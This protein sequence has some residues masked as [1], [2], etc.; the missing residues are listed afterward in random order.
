MVNSFN[1]KLGN[2]DDVEKVL[3]A[4]IKA[5]DRDGSLVV[6]SDKESYPNQV[7]YRLYLEGQ[8]AMIQVSKKGDGSINLC[9]TSKNTNL[10]G[11][12]CKKVKQLVEEP[13]KAS[14]ITIVDDF[15]TE[16]KRDYP[17]LYLYSD[18]KPRSYFSFAIMNSC[19]MNDDDYKVLS[20]Y[21]GMSLFLNTYLTTIGVS[22][23]NLSRFK[24][25]DGFIE[26][27][28]N[29]ITDK[30]LLSKVL[31][32]YRLMIEI[33]NNYQEPEHRILSLHNSE[34]ISSVIKD[35]MD[36]METILELSNELR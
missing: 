4:A 9:P 32:L 25:T 22:R 6:A 10:S 2:G 20:L 23:E 19:C 11:K 16:L 8:E 7:N 13:V 12:V 14:D 24:V 3:E 5:F 31:K 36:L 18:E 30:G 34:F 26:E 15:Y 17:N 21:R 33:G 27:L 1:V 29:S 28:N 35:A